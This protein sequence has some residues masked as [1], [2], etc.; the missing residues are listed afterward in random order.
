MPKKR[1]NAESMT[2]TIY[3]LYRQPELRVRCVER[4]HQIIANYGWDR[5]VPQLATLYRELIESPRT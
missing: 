5:R 2:D 1:Y 3:R 4:A